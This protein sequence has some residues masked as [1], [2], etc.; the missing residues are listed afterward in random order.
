MSDSLC[1]GPCTIY[2]RNYRVWA[3]YFSF[4]LRCP[5]NFLPISHSFVW[6]LPPAFRHCA[7]TRSLNPVSRSP[8]LIAAA[9]RT[10]VPHIAGADAY[11]EDRLSWRL[12]GGFSRSRFPPPFSVSRSH[13]SHGRHSTGFRIVFLPPSGNNVYLALP[14]YYKIVS[15]PTRQFRVSCPS[16]R[17]CGNGCFYSHTYVL[18]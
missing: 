9:P 15:I 11:L 8:C 7:A 6:F 2:H 17:E 1:H 16:P 14:Y 5:A 10:L 18:V 13:A 4:A 12:P 3:F